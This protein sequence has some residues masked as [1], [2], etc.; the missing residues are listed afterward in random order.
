[1]FCCT[2][3]G[4]EMCAAYVFVYPVPSLLACS[5]GFDID[6]VSDWLEESYDAGYW[7]I[8]T[9][10]GKTVEDLID[11]GSIE[12]VGDLHPAFWSTVGGQWDSE[13]EGANAMYDKLVNDPIYSGRTSVC[14]KQFGVI[15]ETQSTLEDTLG[16]FQ[17]HC[18]DSCGHCDAEETADDDVSSVDTLLIMGIAA[19]AVVLVA[20]VIIVMFSRHQI[21]CINIPTKWTGFLSIRTQAN[22][23]RFF[24]WIG[25]RI[26]SKPM[27][28]IAFGAALVVLCCASGFIYYRLFCDDGEC[29]ENRT[30]YLWIPQRSAVWSQYTEIIDVF[31][32]YSSVL[33]LVLTVIDDEDSMLTPSNM[34]IAFEIANSIDNITLHDLNDRDYE[35][36]DLCTRS[37]PTQSDCDSSNETFFAVYFQNNESLW[38]D[39]NST[40]SIINPDIPS[41]FEMS[42]VWLMNNGSWDDIETILRILNI[43]DYPTSLHLG[44]LEYDAEDPTYVVEAKSLRSTYK[45]QGSTDKAVQDA[46][47]Q[48]ARAWNTY[49]NEHHDDYTEHFEITYYSGPLLDDEIARLVNGDAITFAAAFLLM[50]IYL[51]FTLGKFSCIGARPW[52]ALSAVIVLIGALAIGFSIA[53]CCGFAFNS[54]VM[55]VSFILLGVGVDDMS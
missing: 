20:V 41:S 1:M 8:N 51:M 3:K 37:S 39:M 53:L 5:S 24:Q 23:R 40:L 17:E 48:Y 18:S 12:R 29:I 38:N 7:T 6:V 30:F 15:I 55:L 14:A 43:P 31:G 28:F 44:G 49:W 26:H 25:H 16:N 13:K 32:P 33:T 21:R 47:Y 52:L 54:I 4:N 36:T 9:S 19:V 46:V 11:G 2:R 34:D 50:L 22:T 35:Y 10:D 27:W 45:L 42:F